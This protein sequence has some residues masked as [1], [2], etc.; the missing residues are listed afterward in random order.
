MNVRGL[1]SSFL[2]VATLAACNEA[3]SPDNAD[4]VGTLLS[5]APVSQY[6]EYRLRL[7]N[8]S[9]RPEDNGANEI[10]LLA[11][12]RTPVYIRESG[13]PLRRASIT[14]LRAGARIFARIG[15]DVVLDSDP[16]QYGASR[17]D[18]EQDLAF[19]DGGD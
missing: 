13:G 9:V 10:F 4:A 12:D 18:A 11:T 5:A 1:A 8:L 16:A 17:I 19:P 6:G 3:L 14:Q 2:V 15:S 7:Y